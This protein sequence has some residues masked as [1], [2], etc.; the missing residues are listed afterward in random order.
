MDNSLLAV[1]DINHIYIVVE[2][3]EKITKQYFT[4]KQVPCQIETFQSVEWFVYGLD[5]EVFD[6]YILDVEMPKKNGM[7]VAREIRKR[8]PDPVIIFVTNYVDYAVDAYEVNTYRYI[9]KSML[10]QK[11]LSAYDTLLPELLAKE[12]RYYVIEKHT[13]I[14]KISYDSIIYMRKEGKYVIFY[15]SKGESSVRKPMSVVLE[16]LNAKEF[17]V[18]DKGYAV[19]IKH[20]MGLKNHEV[21]MRDGT[22]LPVGGIKVSQVSQA[23][24]DY[25][26]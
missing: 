19:N 25:W 14:E 18:I 9:P 13:D 16:E 17:L 6:L 4:H 24:A 10:E 15:H 5:E 26:K 11:L 22:I 1:R 21:Y 23:I 8:Y 7:D 12:E 3:E 20:I 2:K